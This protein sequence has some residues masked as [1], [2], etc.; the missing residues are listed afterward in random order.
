[1]VVTAEKCG[2]VSVWDATD[3]SLQ[4]QVWVLSPFSR[5]SRPLRLAVTFQ[6]PVSSAHALGAT[7]VA[8]SQNDSMGD[9]GKFG[10][11]VFA[12]CGSDG[13]VNVFDIMTKECVSLL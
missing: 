1:M 4:W 11:G 7:S 6:I 3:G 13:L 10:V 5:F 12:T 2:V 9:S 8:C